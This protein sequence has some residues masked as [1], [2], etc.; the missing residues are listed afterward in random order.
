MK[1]KK[2]QKPRIRKKE[3]A[4]KE[5]SKSNPEKM[6]DLMKLLKFRFCSSCAWR[7]AIN[8][9]YRGFNVASIKRYIKRCLKDPVYKRN[10][11]EYYFLVKHDI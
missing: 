5:K 2:P 4:K 7:W 8:K 3:K 6:K 11:R 9:C 1:M 10:L